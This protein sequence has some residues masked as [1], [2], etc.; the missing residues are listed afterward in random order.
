MTG[1][2]RIEAERACERLVNTYANLIDGYDYDGFMQLW[3]DDAVWNVL[4]RVWTGKAGIRQGL[5]VRDPTMI[6]RHLVTNIVI[7]VVNDDAAVGVCY[8][9][10]YRALNH[11]DRAP[12]PLDF[13]QFLV[14]Y[15]D[16]FV[17]DRT[18]G[19]L[20]ARRDIVSALQRQ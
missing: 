2:Q 20:F 12:G 14:D 8:S 13:P 10:A 18:R 19:W 17:R 16:A 6:C 15:R 4:G 3:A 9:I 11:R 1:L 5:E 7:D